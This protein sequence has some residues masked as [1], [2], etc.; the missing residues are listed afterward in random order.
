[1]V[2][3]GFIVEGAS[4]KILFDS[5]NFRNYLTSININYIPDVINAEGCDNLLPHNIEEYTTILKNKGAK[6]IFVIT[7]L[8]TDECVTK[9]KERIEPSEIHQCVVSKKA[10]EAWFLSD[11]ET[12]RKYFSAPDFI[13]DNPEDLAN[14]F[15]EIHKLK[16]QHLQRGLGTSKIKL[17][18]SL[19]NIGLSFEN[20]LKHPNCSSAKY[21]NSKLLQ[22]SNN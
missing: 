12:M 5:E 13:F 6:K 19:I 7:D 22:Y 8:D 20:I 3:I 15:D 11:T 17:A 2:T 16:L 21:F 1:M 10:I 14:P 9:T 4:E 18:K